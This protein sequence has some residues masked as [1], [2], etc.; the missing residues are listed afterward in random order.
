MASG[1]CRRDDER[2]S[3]RRHQC[4][5]GAE[6]LP[7]AEERDALFRVVA[8]TLT[9]AGYTWI[10]LDLFV[11][12]TDELALAHADRRLHC[13][14]IG[15]TA[16]PVSHV[17]GFGN[18]A[19][20]DV[21]D[22]VVCNEALQP[23]WQEMIV[24]GVFPVAYAHRRSPDEARRCNAIAH[25]LCN[26]ELPARLVADG[27]DDAYARLRRLAADGLVA[28]DGDRIAVTPSGRFALDR[29]CAVLHP[30]ATRDG[31]AEGVQ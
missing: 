6:R 20:G 25:L 19:T 5:I 23:T 28:E 30:A 16:T 2:P 24:A 8:A 31:S 9:D 10:G 26:L 12:D 21:D 17:L 14:V 27:L 4:A 7:G 18:G 11:L 13:N 1:M 15:Y 29:L 3:A 22:T